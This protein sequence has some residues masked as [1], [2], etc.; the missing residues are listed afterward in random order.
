MKDQRTYKII[1]AAMEVKRRKM[2]E[3]K[4]EKR[5]KKIKSVRDLKVYRKA[6]DSAMEIFEITKKFPKKETYSLTYQIRRASRSVCSNLS[7][8]IV[9][10]LSVLRKSWRLGAR[11]Y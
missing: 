1:G 9:L 8:A 2:D 11:H 3:G 10:P 4:D 7:E 6:F 5:T